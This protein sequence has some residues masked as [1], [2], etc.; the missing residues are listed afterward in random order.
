M[1]SLAALFTP[2]FTLGLGALPPHLYSHG[3]S[4]LGT[5]QQVA[6]AF[7]TALA[8]TVM[9]VRAEHLTTHGIAANLAQL[10]GVRLAFLIGAVISVVVAVLAL[11][12][13]A[14]A[15]LN[16]DAPLDD[17]HAQYNEEF[18]SSAPARQ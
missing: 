15:E 4:M 8:V 17:P 18:E 2:V 13:P 14:R 7:G 16:P 11:R 6:A 10:G 1:V 9:T 3:S 12:M 5:L